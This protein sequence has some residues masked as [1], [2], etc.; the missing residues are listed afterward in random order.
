MAKDRV[1]KLLKMAEKAHQSQLK[2]HDREM[3]QMEKH[4]RKQNRKYNK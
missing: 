4:I 1:E 3:K 2:K